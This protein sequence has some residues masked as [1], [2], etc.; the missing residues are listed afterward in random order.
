MPSFSGSPRRARWYQVLA[1][2]V[3]VH[4]GASSASLLIHCDSVHSAGYRVLALEDGRRVAVWYPAAQPERSMAHS[5]S[6][7]AGRVAVDSPPL[8]ACPPVPL[9]LFSHEFGGCALQSIFITE[10]LARHGYVVAAPDHRDAG[11]PIG[12]D[13]LWPLS[14]NKWFLPPHLWSDE[15]AVDRLDDLR[16]VVRLVGQVQRSHA[17]S[18]RRT[19]V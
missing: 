18:M 3:A 5:R 17:S 6:G 10:E 9:V 7:G 11:C 4:A 8:G 15:S 19:S 1:A 16:A 12:S 14:S 13:N 2:F